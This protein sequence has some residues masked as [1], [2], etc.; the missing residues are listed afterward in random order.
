[1]K[2]ILR[3]LLCWSFA[4]AASVLAADMID[5]PQK[6][7][8]IV[9]TAKALA[10]RDKGKAIVAMPVHPF[11]TTKRKE[12]DAEKPES[13]QAPVQSA[14]PA[15]PLPPTPR[16]IL[17]QIAAKLTPSGTMVIGDEP[18]LVINK[19]MLTV[20]SH[21][22]VSLM[23]QEYDVEISAIT[24]TTFTLKMGAVEVTRTTKVQN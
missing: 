18:R 10:G 13:V 14:N 3:A 4:G 12:G 16:E 7:Q 6:R 15:V 5:A 22:T 1:V 8:A 9:S 11:L 17:E 19:S 24:L 23:Q 21:L 20:G 2:T